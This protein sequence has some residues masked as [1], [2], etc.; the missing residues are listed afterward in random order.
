M[1]KYAT[2]YLFILLLLNWVILKFFFYRC[3]QC[4]NNILV[5]I[6]LHTNLVSLKTISRN[7]Y[8]ESL[9]IFN[10]TRQCQSDFQSDSD[11][12][13]QS[14]FCSVSSANIALCQLFTVTDLSVSSHFTYCVCCYT[15][16]NSSVIKSIHSFIH[17]VFFDET[18]EMNDL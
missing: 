1:Y 10:F 9:S 15:T 8:I 7:C 16:V 18:K 4:C 13:T 3:K 5:H 11:L 6:L 12:E 2:I 17:G 14:F